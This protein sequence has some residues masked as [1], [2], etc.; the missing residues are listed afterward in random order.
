MPRITGNKRKTK[1]MAVRMRLSSQILP[2]RRSPREN[3]KPLSLKD[4]TKRT[5]R[6]RRRG[7]GVGDDRVE[8]EKEAECLPATGKSEIKRI[9]TICAGQEDPR[10]EPHV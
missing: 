2:R 8:G 10:N 9:M 6:R 4:E 5:R 1:S 7:L 3:E